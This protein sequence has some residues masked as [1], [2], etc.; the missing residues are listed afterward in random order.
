MSG[1][2]S[3]CSDHR[4]DACE[5]IFADGKQLQL[6]PR[7][8]RDPTVKRGEHTASVSIYL[9]TVW[10]KSARAYLDAFYG[11]F[12]KMQGGRAVPR[13]LEIAIES[14][15]PDRV[16][17]KL[18]WHK[19]ERPGG[20]QARCVSTVEK[21]LAQVARFV[22]ESDAAVKEH[23]VLGQRMIDSVAVISNDQPIK[24]AAPCQP[25]KDVPSASVTDI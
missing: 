1:V 14:E 12:F 6:S 20:H 23:G 16:V 22:A 19:G 9:P 5:E 2:V 10:Q 7:I 3:V 17:G 11:Q 13:D 25:S 21:G 15:R 4:D 24:N 18:T 8:E